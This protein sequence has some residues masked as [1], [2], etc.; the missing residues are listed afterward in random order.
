MSK[1]EEEYSLRYPASQQLYKRACRAI[2]G[3]VPHDSRYFTPFP[4]AISRASGA[5][6][7]E[8]GGERL[9]DY[10]MGHGA[11][12]LGHAHPKIVEAVVS[13]AS[14]G[15]HYGAE[16][17]LQVEWAELIQSMMPAA[18][19]VRFVS[20][21]SEATQLAIR[22]ARAYTGR[23]RILKFA[24][25]FHGWHDEAVAGGSN[26]AAPSLAGLSQRAEEDTI[27][28]PV[29]QLEM[30][31]LALETGDIA[32]IMVEPSG[33]S[34]GAVP[35]SPEFLEGLRGLTHKYKTLL[36]FD[37]VITG[38][39]V[40]TGGA[41]AAF[42]WKP[43]ITCLAKIM[44]GGLPGGAVVGKRAVMELLEFRQDAKWNQQRKVAHFGTFNANPLS[45]AAGVAT[46]RLIQ[47]GEP[48]KVANALCDQLVAAINDVLHS[49]G[50][51]GVAYNQ[52]SMFHIALG[53]PSLPTGS[54]VTPEIQQQLLVAAKGRQT[55]LL[56]QAMLLEGVDL[57]RTGGFVSAAHTADN[58]EQTVTA[59][60]RALLRLATDGYL[61]QLVR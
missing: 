21:G 56:R 20:S 48:I 11:L 3:G 39:R 8:L 25:H 45:S 43:D 2:A 1:L 32:A 46:L 6:K 26:P 17:V 47:S 24:G 41:Q 18:E 34:W 38:F 13:Q 22:L 12:L 42:A 23:R 59:F 57:M 49:F 27:L 30:V 54:E 7:W 53:V 33:G 28:V 19:L 36:V 10:W 14:K 4:P 35:L 5:Y 16:H 51:C 31:E 60:S 37:E 50:V 52:A 55:Q 61:P 9:L 40:D 15:T 58:I 29:G 44:A